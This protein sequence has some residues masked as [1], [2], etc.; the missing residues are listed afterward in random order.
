MKFIKKLVL[1]SLIFS[2]VSTPALAMRKDLEKMRQCL[3]ATSIQRNYRDYKVRKE[4]IAHKFARARTHNETQS[5][6][7]Q[8]PDEVLNNIGEY[9]TANELNRLACTSSQLSKIANDPKL[10]KVIE[11]WPGFST[12]D[13]QFVEVPEGQLPDGTAIASFQAAQYPV[14]QA[15]WQEIMV[16]ERIS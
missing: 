5:L 15:L 7:L 6:L 11:P 1:V 10:R 3:A 9:L 12:F 8:M 14:T 16:A 2:G 4:F 13:Q